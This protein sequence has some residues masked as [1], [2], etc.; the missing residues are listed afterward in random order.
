MG[1]K[2]TIQKN[3]QELIRPE[4]ASRDGWAPILA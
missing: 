4:Q 2:V 3:W 1:A